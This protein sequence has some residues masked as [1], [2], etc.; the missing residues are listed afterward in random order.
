MSRL[1]KIVL[2]SIFPYCDFQLESSPTIDQ[3]MCKHR[4]TG[5]SQAVWVEGIGRFRV[6]WKRKMNSQSL[7]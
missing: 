7:N 3:I 2:S 5:C 6:D 1:D 4:F